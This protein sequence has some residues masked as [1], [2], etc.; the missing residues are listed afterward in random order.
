LGAVECSCHL[1][2]CRRLRLGASQFQ[3]SPEEKMFAR[4]HLN[5]K[6]LGMVV[7]AYHLS[8]RAMCKIGGFWSRL[9][10]VKSETHQKQINKQTK[11]RKKYSSGTAPAYQVKSFEFNPQYHKKKK[12]REKE[13]KLRMN[14]NNRST[15]LAH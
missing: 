15:S 11:Q 12:E 6:K 7:S 14:S 1:K 4:P 13:K 8:H 2:L 3:A 10:W 9:A 5:G